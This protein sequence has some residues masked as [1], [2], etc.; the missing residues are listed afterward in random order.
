MGHSGM[1]RLVALGLAASAV[2]ACGRGTP[3]RDDG[4]PATGD[5]SGG[6][7]DD[8]GGSTIDGGETGSD[9]GGMGPIDGGQIGLACPAPGALPDGKPFEDYVID[10]AQ[11]FADAAQR[12]TWSVEGGPC[13]EMFASEGKPTSFTLTGSQTSQLTIRPTQAG[14]YTIHLEIDTTAG[15]LACTF[16]VHIAASGLR[17]ELCWPTSGI[18]DLDLHVHIPGTTTDWFDDN[19]DCYYANCASYSLTHVN[20][21]Y[22]VST[23]TTCLDGATGMSSMGACPNPRLDQ[24]N[25]EDEGHPEYTNIDVPDDR[26]TYRVMANYFGGAE[27]VNPMANIYCQGKLVA[28]FGRA[29]NLVQGFAISGGDGLGAMWRVADITTHV[30]AAG[31]TTC[32]VA[33]LHPAGHTSGYDVRI[34]D[35]RY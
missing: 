11:L 2:I 5:D 29:P 22:P 32:D 16:V 1:L 28:T 18:D 34:G 15:P 25:T 8:G 6:S 7:G 27:R 13:D 14:D 17:I 26:A 4:G 3:L 21:G 10:G 35:P 33:P 20:W 24:D 30:D 23:M 31:A 19:D 12:W 9:G